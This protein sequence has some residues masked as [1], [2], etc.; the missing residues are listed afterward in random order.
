[1]ASRGKLSQI[2]G[3]EVR[4]LPLKVKKLHKYHLSN[5][6]AKYKLCIC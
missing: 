3:S 1:M 5:N 2:N 6:Y 4:V